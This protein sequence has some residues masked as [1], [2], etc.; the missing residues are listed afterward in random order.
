MLGLYDV[1]SNLSREPKCLVHAFDRKKRKFQL[2]D[3]VFDRHADKK[4]LMLMVY[5]APR[6]LT[7]TD[8]VKLEIYSK[9]ESEYYQGVLEGWTVLATAQKIDNLIICPG[10]RTRAEMIDAISP[11]F[12]KEYAGFEF[13]FLDGNVV[14]YH[15]NG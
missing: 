7:E 8:K 2:Y 13:R 14:N 11:D 9:T 15:K 5:I 6:T 4:G 10:K 12:W 1:E 3:F